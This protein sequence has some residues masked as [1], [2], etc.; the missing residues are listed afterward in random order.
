MNKSGHGK[1]SLVIEHL[2]GISRAAIKRYPDII[3]EFVRRKS[4]VYALYKGDSL[5]YVG[6]AKN[7]RS[8]LHGHLRDRH[9]DAWD[10]FNVYLTQSDEHLK[11]L[12][13]LVLRIA[14]PMGNRVTG[15]FMSSKDL[16]RVFR[17]RIVESQKREL[18][19]ITLGD[20]PRVSADRGV[21]RRR[22]EYDTIVCPAH[23]EGFEKE[24]LGRHRWYAIRIS[25]K[26]IPRLKYIAIYVSRPTCQITHYGRIRAIKPWRDSGKQI[27]LLKDKPK[28]L[29]P[30]SSSAKISM[31]SSRLALMARLKRAQTLADA[32]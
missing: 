28:R 26:V 8:R 6:L 17:Q 15:K 13:S 19:D 7:L 10:H 5:Y 11:E 31:Q 18:A 12:E 30:I 25:K 1:S 9:A 27:V 16:L 14:S 24:F 4:G 29:G 21:R 22:G 23:Q 2:E 20:V 3:T 32:M